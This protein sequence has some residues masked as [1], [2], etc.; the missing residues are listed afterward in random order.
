MQDDE[1]MYE[2]CLCPD[3]EAGWNV[4]STFTEFRLQEGRQCVSSEGPSLY[5]QNKS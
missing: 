3:F 5:L 2:V 1:Y 4:K